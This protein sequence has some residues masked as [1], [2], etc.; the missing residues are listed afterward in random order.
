MIQYNWSHDNQGEG[1]LL[2]S[3]PVGYGYSRGESH[4]IQMRYNLSERDGKKLGGGI[5]VFGGVNPLVIYNNTV[6]YEPDRLAGTDMFN[7]EGG[8]VTTSIFGKSGKP[9][10]RTYN[11]IFITNGRTNPAAASNNL[12][13]DGAGTFT[14]NNNIWWRVEGGSR[15][16]WANS[17]ITS[18][19]SWTAQ[20]FDPGGFNA[21]PSV[22][23]PLG[24]SP[25]AYRLRAGSVAIDHGRT[26]ADALRGMGLQD[27]F[28]AT[29][30]QGVAYDIGA[31]EYRLLF[32]DPAMALLTGLQHQADESW[33]LDFSGV[34]GRS[35]RVDTSPDLR[36]WAGAGTATETSAGAFTFLD[37]AG[38]SPRFYRA[39]ARAVPGAHWRSYIQS[40]AAR[41]VRQRLSASSASA[42]TKPPA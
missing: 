34:S 41:A 38:G 24:G 26:V 29:T 19:N 39:V 31:A 37:Q 4:N 5:T 2:L 25:D 23:G 40:N 32:P 33:R 36:T 14:F 42:G 22:A 21:N 1:Y 10:M 18:W 27:A 28:A 35:Y 3:W 9:D 11:N 12:W 17:V 30:P 20:G 8:A 16:Q 6:Y 13:T 15:F 7:G